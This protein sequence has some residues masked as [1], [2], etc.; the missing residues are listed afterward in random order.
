MTEVDE[1]MPV[2]FV[3][4]SVEDAH[5]FW[6]IAGGSRCLVVNVPDLASA[7]M[8][9]A[10][11]RPRLVVCDTEIEGRGSWRDLLADRDAQCGFALVVASRHADERLW[12]EVLNLGGIDVLETPFEEEEVERV[13]CSRVELGVGQ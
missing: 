6:D 2:V 12:A 9:F 1:R 10:K 8:V 13:I 5:S 3:S 4:A 11:L 7:R